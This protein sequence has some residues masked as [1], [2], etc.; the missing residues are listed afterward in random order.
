[1]AKA[2]RRTTT[3]GGRGRAPADGPQARLREILT[4]LGRTFPDAHCELD[5][6]TP[7]DLLVATILSA[8]CTDARVN[9]VRQ[10][11]QSRQILRA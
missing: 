5:F 2:E 1:M 6:S 4:I 10:N 9:Q 8:Q 7:L 3:A 11:F